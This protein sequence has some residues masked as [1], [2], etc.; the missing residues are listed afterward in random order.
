MT[1]KDKSTS[2]FSPR[3]T[4]SFQ[5]DLVKTVD[6]RN[7]KT[8]FRLNRSLMKHCK[9]W[10]MHHINWFNILPYFAHSVF[11]IWYTTGLVFSPTVQPET[12]KKSLL[13]GILLISPSKA[14]EK[15]YSTPHLP[16]RNNSTEFRHQK[17]HFL[18][19]QK[20]P[21]DRSRWIVGKEKVGKCWKKKMV[22]VPSNWHLCGYV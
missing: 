19:L 12:P 7:H 9:S 18:Q 17:L 4:Q 20:A 3:S 1:A 10:D 11:I 21:W 8:Q 5:E 6:G 13:I 15:P 22:K 2:V 16:S 14:R